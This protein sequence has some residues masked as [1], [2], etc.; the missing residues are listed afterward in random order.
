MSHQE[1]FNE[2]VLLFELQMQLQPSQTI[3]FIGNQTPAHTAR[4]VI[5]IHSTHVCRTKNVLAINSVNTKEQS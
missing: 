4:T 3:L 2:N 5:V 1:T